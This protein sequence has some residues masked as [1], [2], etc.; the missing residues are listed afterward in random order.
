MGGSKDAHCK[1]WC[2]ILTEIKKTFEDKYKH[3]LQVKKNNSLKTLQICKQI[4]STLY[5]NGIL[6]NQNVLSFY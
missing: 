3:N 2:S 4:A 6:S 1:I 5:I